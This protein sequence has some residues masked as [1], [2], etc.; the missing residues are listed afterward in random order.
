MKFSKGN[1]Q[2]DKQE[3][4]WSFLYPQYTMV[5]VLNQNVGT[6]Y[7]SQRYVT[8]FGWGTSGFHD[9]N[10]VINQRNYPYTTA[11][12]NVTTPWDNAPMCNG[13]GPTNAGTSTT[14]SAYLYTMPDLDFA[15]ASIDYDWGMHNA[16]ENGGNA[17]GKWRTLTQAEWNYLLTTRTTNVTI[18]NTANARYTMA[19]IQDGN[20]YTRGLILIPDEITDIMPTEVEWGKINGWTTITTIN[21]NNWA[22]FEKAGFVFLPAAGYRDG[23]TINDANQIGH[24]WSSS[25]YQLLDARSLYMAANGVVAIVGQNSAC[26]KKRTNG[27]SVRLVRDAN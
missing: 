1:L 25:Y 27:H 7:A 26:N 5:E 24:Y 11:N 12:N 6:D 14:N 8:L 3:D 17:P 16:I 10:D 2:Y 15:G 21:K 22:A 20:T 4:E 9:N 18:G 13:F 23:T 19:D